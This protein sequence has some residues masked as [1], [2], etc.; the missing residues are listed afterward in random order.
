MPFKNFISLF[1]TE[2][3]GILEICNSC[4][5]DL[6]ISTRFPIDPRQTNDSFQKQET[7]LLINVATPPRKND[8]HT[9]A[10]I[11]ARHSKITT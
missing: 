1:I 6:K 2:N 7:D 11:P 5:T 9:T 4:P 3:D 8:P 10:V